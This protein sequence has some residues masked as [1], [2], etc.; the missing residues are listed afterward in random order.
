MLTDVLGD[1]LESLPDDAYPG[2]DQGEVLIQMLVGTV[3]PA[4]HAAGPDT[5]RRATALLGAV[6][7]RF[8]A[9]LEAAR[10]LAARRTH[11]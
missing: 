1:L 7:D 5:V 10:D 9:D 3:T 4:V 2:E 8:V 6:R 11:L